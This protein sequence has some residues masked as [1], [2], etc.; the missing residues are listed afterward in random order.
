MSA[1][2]ALSPHEEK[3]VARM[4]R[5]RSWGVPLFVFRFGFLGGIGGAALIAVL[6]GFVGRTGISGFSLPTRF[7][8]LLCITLPGGVVCALCAWNSLSVQLE[9]IRDGARRKPLYKE[10]ACLW[11]AGLFLL[12]GAGYLSTSM[13]KSYAVV[14]A[15]LSISGA[16]LSTW[17]LLKFRRY[18]ITY[19]TWSSKTFFERLYRLYGMYGLQVFLLIFGAGRLYLVYVNPYLFPWLTGLV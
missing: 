13:G 11:L 16:V 1:L 15:M 17:G 19:P 7:L 6:L 12:L 14:D 8:M 9:L 3:S 4:E 10:S 18:W 5:W 2:S